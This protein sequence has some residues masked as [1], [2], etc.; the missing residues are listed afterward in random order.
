MFTTTNGSSYTL[1]AEGKG[2]G[3]GSGGVSMPKIS[4]IMDVTN[5]STH[6][7]KFSGRSIYGSATELKTSFQFIKL[8]DT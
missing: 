1:I 7:I 3:G 8:G 5:T 2:G 4:L 6:K